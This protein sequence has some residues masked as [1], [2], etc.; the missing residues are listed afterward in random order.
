M[1]VL[2]PQENACIP[3]KDSGVIEA[4]HR[5]IG[6]FVSR[7]DPS[8]TRV[9]NTIGQLAKKIGKLVDTPTVQEMPKPAAPAT[10]VKALSL[11]T[12]PPGYFS[13]DCADKKLRQLRWRRSARIIY[14]AGLRESYG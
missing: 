9:M 4:N 8:Y 12:P 13:F 1:G 2:V 5:R 11:G 6:I 14:S 7:N 10:G 3:G